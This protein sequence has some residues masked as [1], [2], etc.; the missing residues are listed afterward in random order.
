M[1]FAVALLG[2]RSYAQLAC[3]NLFVDHLSQNIKIQSAADEKFYRDTVLNTEKLTS[4][5]QLF[6]ELGLNFFEGKSIKDLEIHLDVQLKVKS[7]QDKIKTYNSIADIYFQDRI[8]EN[9]KEKKMLL[10]Y[11]ADQIYKLEKFDESD[12]VETP[13]VLTTKT[14]LHYIPYLQVSTWIESYVNGQGKYYDEIPTFGGKV[15]SFSDVRDIAS[16]N[17][18]IIEMQGHDVRHAHF[19]LGHPYAAQ[20]YYKMS[21]SKN[22]LRYT[23]AG[24][25][26][27]GVDTAQYS[28]EKKITSYFRT[29]LSL[30]LELGLLFVATRTSEQLENIIE[31]LGI[32]ND[33]YFSTAYGAFQNWR[34]KKHGIYND[35]NSEGHDLDQQL[36]Q[37]LFNIIDYINSDENSKFYN[38]RRNPNLNNTE[39]IEDSI[40]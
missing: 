14:N 23:T 21:R 31:N 6:E 37:Q 22:A 29:Q 8:F 1:L 11:V 16:H 12:Y 30:D 38:Y 3:E 34:P 32:R 18:W 26:F 10:S 35:K 13:F 4:I 39:L 40:F 20:V 7:T 15:L 25:L 27:E 19:L 2:S 28:F 24:A 36:D 9:L 33:S 5:N 17:L